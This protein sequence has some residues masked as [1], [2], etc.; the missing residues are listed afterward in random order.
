M[1]Q[2]PYLIK[3]VHPL[4]ITNS[5]LTWQLYCWFLHVWTLVVL[6]F[7]ATIKWLCKVQS[8][9]IVEFLPSKNCLLSASIY[10]FL[11]NFPLDT[12]LTSQLCLCPAYWFTEWWGSTSESNTVTIGD[13]EMVGCKLILFALNTLLCTYSLVHWHF[14][15]VPLHC[16][17]KSMILGTCQRYIFFLSYECVC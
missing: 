2:W 9:H 1:I 7:I 6:L 12:Q 13:A 17:P 5:V 11:L 8:V 16:H 14:W 15:C 4:M 3:N 10:L